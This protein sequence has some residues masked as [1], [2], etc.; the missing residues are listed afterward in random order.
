M[1]IRPINYEL[2]FEP[3]FHNFKFNGEE[4]IT[5]NLPKSANSIILDAAELT[6]K[7]CDMEHKGKVIP[8]KSSLNE[9]KEELTIKLAKKI[10][11]KA[12]LSIKFT[13]ILNDRLLGFYKSQY[14]DKKGKAKYLATTQFEAADARRAFPCFDEPEAKATFDVSL[15]VDK[16]LDAISN[17]PITSKKN[18]G[19]KILY[20]FGRTPIMSTYLLYLGV[21]EFEYLHG[22]LQNI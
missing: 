21:G 12:K 4:I 13:G 3:L 10:K 20:K 18:V 17:M 15:L 9:K 16:H 2:M 8:V 22:K 1:V 6:V 7:K 11:G 5:L 19:S 14:K